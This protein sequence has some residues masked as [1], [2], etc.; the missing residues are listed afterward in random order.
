MELYELNLFDVIEGLKEKKFSS[1]ELFDS[2]KNRIDACE[3]KIHAL[4]T[5]SYGYF[6]WCSNYL[7]R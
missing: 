5:R 4:I 3:D 6:C 1:S 7:K 2:C